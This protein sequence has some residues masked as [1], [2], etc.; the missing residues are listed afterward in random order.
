M[1]NRSFLRGAIIVLSVITAVIHFT[2]VPFT[3]IPFLLNGL[4]FLVLAAA[5]VF[6]PS[7]LAGRQRLAQYAL[8]A[9]TVV[10]ILAWV[11][12]GDKSLPDG[13]IGYI[14]KI[15]EL[16]LLAAVFQYGRLTKTA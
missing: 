5:V 1:N 13:L 9:F 10:T 11:A 7:F 16:L 12:I 15:D 3:G 6:E 4:G 8:M 14:S 2:R